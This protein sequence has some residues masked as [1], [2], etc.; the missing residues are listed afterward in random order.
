MSDAPKPSEN[1]AFS[2]ML[3]AAKER[4]VSATCDDILSRTSLEFSPEASEF[5]LSSLG[6]TVRVSY[7]QFD[8]TPPINEWHHLI[9]LHYLEMADGTPLS[10]DQI[11]FGELKGGLARGGNFDRECERTISQSLGRKPPE[12]VRKACEALGAQI[13]PSNADLCAVFPFLPMYP[14][15]LKIWFA[16]DE[17]EGTGRMLLNGSADHYLSTEDAVA[18]GE[19]IL[20]AVKE[21]TA[22]MEATK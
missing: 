12:T 15:T 16:D 2:E 20:S 4:L 3:K 10:A 22:I 5:V 14:V 1:R 21:K 8:L 18:V 7:P 6:R 19:L 17:L 11:T 13:I 9:I